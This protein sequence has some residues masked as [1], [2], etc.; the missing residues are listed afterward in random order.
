MAISANSYGSAGNVAALVPKYAN[1]SGVFDTTTRPTLTQ[2][3]T[4]IDQVS[5]ALNSMLA[6]QG[7]EIPVT[8]ADVK[9]ALEMFVNEEVASIAQGIN[10]GGRFG[11]SNAGYTSSRFKLI[12]DDINNYIKGNA[13]GFERLGAVR[14]SNNLDIAYNADDRQPIFQRG[15]FGNGVSED[16][17]DD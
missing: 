11:P 16:W 14:T 3:E 12:N 13:I 10:G 7:F 8:Q 2:V 4:Y 17:V 9:Q 6:E 5:G 15:A 1:G